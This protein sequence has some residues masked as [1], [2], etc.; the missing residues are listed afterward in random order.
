MWG[1]F[2]TLHWNPTQPFLP[3]LRWLECQDEYKHWYDRYVTDVF[4]PLPDL[5]PDAPAIHLFFYAHEIVAQKVRAV[6]ALYKKRTNT[7]PAS[8]GLG[9]G[10]QEQRENF[11]SLINILNNVIVEQ[12]G[13]AVPRQSRLYRFKYESTLALYVEDEDSS[14]FVRRF[15]HEATF[16]LAE[17]LLAGLYVCE[18]QDECRDRLLPLADKLIRALA[19]AS[20]CIETMAYTL[21]L[22]SSDPSIELKESESKLNVSLIALEQAYVS[23]EESVFFHLVPTPSHGQNATSQFYE[24][25][26]WQGIMMLEAIRYGLG[27]G[28]YD[29]EDVES[30]DPSLLL[31]LPTLALA[32]GCRTGLLE[33]CTRSFTPCPAMTPELLA[34]IQALPDD[35]YVALVERIVVDTI[36]ESST[37]ELQDIFIQLARVSSWWQNGPLSASYRDLI[38]STFRLHLNE[39]EEVQA[40]EPVMRGASGSGK[41]RSSFSFSRIIDNM[42][43]HFVSQ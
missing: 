18:Q 34:Q 35:T 5:K 9:W 3:M 23:F 26:Q 7:N 19:S 31:S 14:I 8:S 37:D 42:R 21:A 15:F 28:H 20:V 2:S 30:M 41:R 36:E 6:K 40:A 39:Q 17:A 22:F 32:N 10:V 24:E 38:G 11:Q 4:Y 43:R 1:W 29:P 27:N 12:G 16:Y 33:N 25:Y 13:Q